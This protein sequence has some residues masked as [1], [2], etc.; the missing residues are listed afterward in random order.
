MI[1]NIQI[2]KDFDIKILSVKVNLR[3]PEDADV[4]GNDGILPCIKGSS[5]CPEIEIET[6]KIANWIQGVSASIH[7]KV[8]DE[9]VYDIK[10]ISGETVIHR[11]DYVPSC[12]C[13]KENGYGD[14]IIMDI[15]KEGMI[16]GWKFKLTDFNTED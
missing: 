8:V 1:V 9:G 3:H 14:Y 12:L 6:G 7:F 5:W 10:D 4:I 11:E 15:N 13:P 16:Q 2:E